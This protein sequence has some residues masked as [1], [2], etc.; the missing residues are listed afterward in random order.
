MKKEKGSI[1]IFIVV[2]CLL[3]LIVLLMMGMKITNK[4][5]SQ[6]KDLTQINKNY[7]QNESEMEKQY[8]NLTLNKGT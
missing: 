6:D 3:I 7:K 4:Q 1:T 2:S 5:T 8:Q